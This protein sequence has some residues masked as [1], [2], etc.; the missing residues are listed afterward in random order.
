MM[1]M[2]KT[3]NSIHAHLW[4]ESKILDNRLNKDGHPKTLR[5]YLQEAEK[6]SIKEAMRIDK[7]TIKDAKQTE[8]YR[9]TFGWMGEVLAEYWLL[10]FG[11]LWNIHTIR[12]TSRDQFNRGFDLIGTSK[13]DESKTILIQVKMRSDGFY[14]FVVSDCYTFLDEAEKRETL[15]QHLIFMCPTSKH[16]S[17]E[18]ALSYKD[19]FKADYKD[20][21]VFIG[22]QRMNKEIGKLPV[23]GVTGNE[24]FFG[25]FRESL[26]KSTA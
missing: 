23:Q 15:P 19:N 22:E 4:L 18:D 21:F 17:K 12:E 5:T 26:I 16:K 11:H 10:V 6:W 3:I 1:M 25:S 20:R 7:C 13:Y 2:I 14:R 8:T 9:N 24:Y